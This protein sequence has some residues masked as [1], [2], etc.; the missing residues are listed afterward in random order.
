MSYI[1]GKGRQARETYPEARTLASGGTLVRAG[2]DN[3]VDTFVYPFAPATPILRLGTDPLQVVLTGFKPGNVILVAFSIILEDAEGEPGGYQV[4]L[5][6]A[7]DVGAGIQQI[8]VNSIRPN[9]NTN[10]IP[11][12]WIGA[13]LPPGVTADPII[14]VW[15]RSG[16]S[17][18]VQILPFGAWLT[19][20]EFDV[21]GVTT[22]PSAVLAPIPP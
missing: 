10:D 21:S 1:I 22:L 12:T 18:Q 4:D 14:Q 16:G 6:P 17:D 15:I 5:I 19:A 8:T 3:S 2:F 7:V 11:T 13:V 20:I 9:L